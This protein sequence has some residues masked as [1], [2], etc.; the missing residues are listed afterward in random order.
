MRFLRGDGAAQSAGATLQRRQL[1]ANSVEKADN[2]A[3]PARALLFVT[4]LLL[5]FLLLLFSDGVVAIIV[6]TTSLGHLLL[7]L[8]LIYAAPKGL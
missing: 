8:L 7:L 1:S 2:G 3:R 6:A 4:P 5:R